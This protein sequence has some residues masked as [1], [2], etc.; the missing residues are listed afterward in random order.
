[1]MAWNGADY[2]CKRCGAKVVVAAEVEYEKRDAD[3]VRQHPEC[4]AA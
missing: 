4:E 3:A 2:E 1:M